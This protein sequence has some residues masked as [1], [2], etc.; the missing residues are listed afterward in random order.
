MAKNFQVVFLP[1][2]VR[3]LDKIPPPTRARLIRAAESLGA[4]PIPPGVNKLQGSE[5]HRMRVRD[6]C[7][8]YEV[9]GTVLLV[10][11]IRIGTRGEVYRGL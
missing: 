9:K 2:A 6:Y 8:V 5:F 1:R 11:V 3:S 4:N 7:I 10:T